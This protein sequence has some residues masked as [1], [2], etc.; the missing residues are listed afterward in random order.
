M[1]YDL[2]CYKPKSKSLTKKRPILFLCHMEMNHEE[3]DVALQ[4]MVYDK[5][6]ALTVPYWYQD[7]EAERLFS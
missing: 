5:H 6:V 4:I 7:D 1:S 3:G 2:Y